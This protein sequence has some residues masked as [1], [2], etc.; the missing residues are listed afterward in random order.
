MIRTSP[1]P[2]DLTLLKSKVLQWATSFDV[3][4]CFDSHGYH[5]KYGAFELLIATGTKDELI[6]YSS[7]SCFSDLTTFIENNESLIPGILSYDLKNELEDLHSNNV[8]HIDF[9]LLY[10]F[11]PLHILLIKEKSLIVIS[12]TENLLQQIV[13]RE[14]VHIDQESI[15]INIQSRISKEEYIAEVNAVKQHIQ[16][17]DIY[18]MN[19]CQEFYAENIKISP[20]KLF[21]KLSRISPAPFSSFFKIYDKYVMGGSPERYICRRKN[22]LISQPIKGT[23]P[24]L[25]D[26]VQDSE[27]KEKL[28]KD[29]KEQTENVMIVDLVRND[30][31][32]IAMEGSVKVEELF[33]VY[34]FQQVHQ[35]ISTISCDLPENINNIEILKA[36]FPMGSMTGAPK[37]RAMEIIEEHEKTKRGIYSGAIGYFDTNGEFDF[38]VVIRSIVY[39]EKKQYLSYHTG[40]AITIGCDPEKEYEECLLKGMAIKSVLQPD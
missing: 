1:I 26:P 24:R 31:T 30:L 3:A 23:Y 18:E 4:C 7:E 40:G 28:R 27:Q 19:F 6:S 17:G 29:L 5:D 34:S 33:G 14:I 25:T 12:E 8:D 13:D 36:T 2:G 38:N 9:P 22:K 21:K 35:M 10:F 15:S 11:K 37:I 20:L 39:N 16:R 32:K